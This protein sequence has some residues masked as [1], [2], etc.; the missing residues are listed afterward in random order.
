MNVE[1]VKSL[2]SI[3]G[4]ELCGSF[5]A[6]LRI[7]NEEGF[8]KYPPKA[9]QQKAF[10]RKVLNRKREKCIVKSTA[11][12]LEWIRFLSPQF[13]HEL[14]RDRTLDDCEI[15]IYYWRLRKVF[16]SMVISVYDCG[17]YVSYDVSIP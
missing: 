16:P 11:S 17:G 5:R 10:V 13:Y 9:Y 12:L 1:M 3:C 15:I 14:E 2:K 8:I 4:E 7:S 6:I